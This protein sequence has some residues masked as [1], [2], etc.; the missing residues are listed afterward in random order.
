[1]RL[2]SQ[3]VVWLLA[4]ATFMTSCVSM[5]KYDD[6]EN[7]KNRLQKDYDTVNGQAKTLQSDNTRLNQSLTQSERDRKNCETD[8]STSKER[9]QQLDA[10]N[11]DL[12]MRYD[13]MLAQNQQLLEASSDE[14]KDLT[15]QLSEKQRALDERERTLR[16]LEA[17]AKAKEMK[18]TQLEASLKDREQRVK[19]L[20]TALQEKDAKLKDI[21]DKVNKALLGFSASD[22]S[23]REQDGKIY[24]SLSQNLLF[25]TG[26]KTINADGKGALAKLAQVL[27]ANSDIGIMVEG[28]TDSD[29]DADLNWDLSVMRATSVVKEL[30]LSGIDP[31][32][33]TA[34]GKGEFFPVAPNDTAAGKAQNRRTEI[35]LTPNLQVLYDIIGKQ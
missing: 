29:G 21:R 4:M 35:I 9:Y 7:W 23:V 28:H 14:K 10:T 8:L 33:M 3:Y 34:S 16:D 12:L 30:A 11:R 18:A 1:M 15:T 17:E 13:R 6:M 31:K 32:R 5:R 25:R 27:N 24:V 22:L 2:P 20:E 26:S 19:E